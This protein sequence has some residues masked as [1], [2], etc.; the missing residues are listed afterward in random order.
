M[1]AP[2]TRTTI[3]LSVLLAVCT[4][5]AL[6][7][8]PAGQT[9]SAL[10]ATLL[11]KILIGLGIPALAFWIFFRP[12]RQNRSDPSRIVT[13]MDQAIARNP[14]DVFAYFKRGNAR[15]EQGDR[16][17]AIANYDRFLAGD[18]GDAATYCQRARA[19]YG[20]GNPDQAMADLDQAI[21]CNPYN[22]YACYVRGNL[23]YVQ[24][25]LAGAIADYGQ[26]I[27]HDPGEVYAY[28]VRGRARRPGPVHRT[29][30]CRCRGL[31]CARACAPRSR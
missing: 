2:K 14:N 31:L 16:A 15:Y 30:S 20:Q 5:C 11:L 25:D 1:S 18:P 8:T 21:Q 28:F 13:K 7:E 26:G 17:G 23:R 10:D 24:G 9:Q 6:T 3:A 12:F 27:K 19:H 22:S 4:S 29:P